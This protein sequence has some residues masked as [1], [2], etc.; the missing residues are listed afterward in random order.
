M[1][2]NWKEASVDSFDYYE[3]ILPHVRLTHSGYT[4][5]RAFPTPKGKGKPGKEPLT[6]CAFK[7]GVEIARGKRST[8]GKKYGIH[9]DT[10]SRRIVS[11]KLTDGVLF[12]LASTI[13]N[14]D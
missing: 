12:K 7:N 4:R 14:E 13:E 9:Q 11:G 1:I 2:A 3:H 8:M 10:V 6:V 5:T